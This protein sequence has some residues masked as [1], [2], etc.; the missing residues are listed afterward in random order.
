MWPCVALS[1]PREPAGTSAAAQC[2]VVVLFVLV[3]IDMVDATNSLR[4]RYSGSPLVVVIFGFC[5]LPFVYEKTGGVRV[6]SKTDLFHRNDFLAIPPLEITDLTL[7]HGS[8]RRESS[9]KL[10]PTAGRSITARQDGDPPG[11]VNRVRSVKQAG[12]EVD[13]R[14]VNP[15]VETIGRAAYIP[16]SVKEHDFCRGEVDWRAN[17]RSIRMHR[18]SVIRILCADV[19]TEDHGPLATVAAVAVRQR[20]DGQGYL[21]YE[22]YECYCHYNRK[23]LCSFHR[24]LL[25]LVEFVM[26]QP[27]HL[28]SLPLCFFP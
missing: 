26:E 12:S 16:L 17:Q 18:R 20:W 23:T 9:A 2:V 8:A 10:V 4:L 14:I 6:G 24:S 5:P 3:V 28:T 13:T 25:S 7:G 11:A 21:R 15:R 19:P 22:R 1:Y 27:Q